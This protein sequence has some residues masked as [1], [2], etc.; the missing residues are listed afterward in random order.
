MYEYD[1]YRQVSTDACSSDSFVSSPSTNS[2]TSMYTNT[3]LAGLMKATSCGRQTRH[4]QNCDYFP[5]S[6]VLYVLAV[7]ACVTASK[8]NAKTQKNED[9]STNKSHASKHLEGLRC[10]SVT[11]S[12]TIVHMHVHMHGTLSNRI[13]IV[14][15]VNCVY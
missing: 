1:R 2:R 12:C 8:R 13:V 6:F 15:V 10:A 3:T 14:V 4:V 7:T 11:S 9:H 5:E